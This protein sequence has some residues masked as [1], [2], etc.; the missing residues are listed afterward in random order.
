MSA[1]THSLRPATGLGCHD[2]GMGKAREPG[3]DSRVDN[4]RDM[5]V[6]GDLR[7]PL[8]AFV[9]TEQEVDELIAVGLREDGSRRDRAIGSRR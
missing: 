4:P 6:T 9:M 1:D 7:M 2:G 5:E 3:P 8:T